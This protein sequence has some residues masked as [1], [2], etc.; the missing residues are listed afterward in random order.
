MKSTLVI[1]Y[2]TEDNC[3]LRISISEI[4]YKT[5]VRTELTESVYRQ[6]LEYM[7]GNRSTFDIPY[8]LE[9]TDFQ[10]KVWT[11]LCDI[12]YGETRSYKQIAQLLGTPNGSRAIGNANNYNPLLIVV[13]CHRVISSRGILRGYAGG[14]DMQQQLLTL[15]KDNKYKFNI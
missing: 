3:V 6:I 12:P 1:K 15:E 13:P 4:Q 2:D 7:D 14:I 9:G 11:S 5:N 10:K 8:R